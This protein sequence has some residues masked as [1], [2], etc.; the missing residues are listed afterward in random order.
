MVSTHVLRHSPAVGA[1]IGVATLWSLGVLHLPIH[2]QSVKRTGEFDRREVSVEEESYIFTPQGRR[3]EGKLTVA[4]GSRTARLKVR[5]LDRQTGWPTF[6]RVNIVGVKGNYYA[7]QGNYLRPYG[8]KGEWP[9]TGMGNRRSKAPIRY[10]GRFFYSNGAFEVDVPEGPTRI[11]VWKGFE[12]RPLMRETELSAGQT[13]SV[14]LTLERALHMARHAYYGGDPHI[15]LRRKDDYDD[16][17]IFDLMEAEDIRFASILC[18]NL[19]DSYTGEMEHQ[20]SPQF[21]GLGPPS[22]RVRAD[23][24]IMSA[25]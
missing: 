7:P 16:K 24:S 2:A 21:R 10:L 11:E 4:S 18:Y 22:L 9:K 1:A 8:M 15:H 14:T 17:I 3:Q 25:Q 5:I 12:Y 23:Y 20:E 6:C 19:L 13:K